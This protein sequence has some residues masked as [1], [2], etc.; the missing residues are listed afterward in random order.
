VIDAVRLTYAALRDV[1]LLREGELTV[2]GIDDESPQVFLG[3]DREGRQHLLVESP[4]ADPLDTGIAAISTTNR[5]L[6]IGADSRRYLDVVCA[7]MELA[8]VF[9]HFVAAVVER[10]SPADRDPT[11]VVADILDQWR[12][13]FAEMGAPPARERVTSVIGELLLLR[14]VAMIDPVDVLSI[15]VGPRGSRHDFRRGL[16]A[17]EVKATRSHTSRAVTVHGEDQLQ[18]PDGGTLHLHFVRLEEVAGLGVCV[19]DLAD[20]LVDLGVPRV[21][22]FEALTDA[23]VPPASFVTVGS[24]RFDVRERLTFVV[25]DDTPRIIPST[26]AAGQRPAGIVDLTYRADLDHI[27]D[28]ALDDPAYLAFVRSLTASGATQ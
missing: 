4:D 15:W 18:P 2:R 21:A 12:S 28:S 19:I 16:D 20:E 10:V 11:T 23:G 7:M 3:L 5:D 1:V 13:F 24:V 27:A 26:F 9:D 22:L 14:D 25:D 6:M 8:D 17:V